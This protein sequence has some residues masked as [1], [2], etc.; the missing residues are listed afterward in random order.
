MTNNHTLNGFKQQKS[1]LL[2]L[3]RPEVQ[4]GF[5][6]QNQGVGRVLPSGGAGGAISVPFPV[7]QLPSLLPST[8][9]HLQS[10]QWNISLYCF[11]LLPSHDVP[12]FCL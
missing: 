10:Q 7:L 3:D 9:L 1:T 12:L 2:Q 6:G 11:F 8:F 5:S 4:N